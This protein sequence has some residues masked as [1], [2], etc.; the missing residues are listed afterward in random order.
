MS[1]I[2]R[3]PMTQPNYDQLVAVQSR[4][5]R[6]I[7]YETDTAQYGIKEYW[8]VAGKRGD[9]ED[10]A[11]AKMKALRDMGWPRESLDIAICKV[12][13]AGHA[14]LVAHTDGGDIVLDNMQDRPTGW[15]MLPNYEWIETSIGGSFLHWKAIEG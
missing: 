5:N 8:A 12:G 15:Q 1:E 11:L 3:H 9:C 2:V 13:G 14:V 6:E 4:V 7:V 10:I